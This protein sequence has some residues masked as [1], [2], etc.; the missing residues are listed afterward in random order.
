MRKTLMSLVLVSVLI[1]VAS[2][3][4]SGQEPD[5]LD[6]ILK[7]GKIVI[8]IINDFPP[9][10]F[11]DEKGELDGYDVD[12]AKDLAKTLG[13]SVEW[14]PVTNET[15]SA[16]LVSDKV[17]VVFSNYTRT[18][19]RA[20]V[21]DF[22]NPYVVTGMSILARKEYN[23][24]TLKEIMSKGIKIGVGKGTIGDLILIEKY[25]NANKVV[26]DSMQD[27]LMALKQNKVGAILE[28]LTW[29]STQ[30]AKDSN[31]VA[32]RELLATD[33]NCVAIRRGQP[34]W[35]DW[36]NIWIDDLNRSGRNR[37]YFIKRFGYEPLKLTPSY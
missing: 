8:G 24:T 23:V 3:I 13:V 37:D 35:K 7:R 4:S 9:V 10:G 16:V 29:V 6:Q 12:L 36:L 27:C 17:D 1:L 32:V 18:P 14:V 34:S 33:V 21:I 25:P 15:R 28:D 30:A 31:L 22:T 20:K 5:R 19:E 2:G 26:F 11:Y